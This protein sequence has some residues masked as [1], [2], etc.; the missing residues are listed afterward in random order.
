MRSKIQAS[1]SGLALTL[2]PFAAWAEEAA[3][4]IPV[5]SGGI[6]LNFADMISTVI[7]GLIGIFL[8]VVGYFIFDWI[9]PY[10]LGKELVEDKNVAVAIVVAAILL[11]VAII[12]SA[13]M[14]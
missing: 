14:R 3:K 7:Y 5:R 10:S 8:A 4:E 13:A 1:L 11:S 12:V 6:H 2:A 9:T